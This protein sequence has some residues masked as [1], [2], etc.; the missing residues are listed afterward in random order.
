M[1]LDTTNW[2]K[3]PVSVDGVDFVSQ[4]DMDGS[5]Y[6]QLVNMPSEVFQAFHADMIHSLIGNPALISR[7]DLLEELEVINL[8][9]TQAILA[10][11]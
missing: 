11:A 5:F 7:E 10:L 2:A 1:S 6:P 9:A 8:G 4:I 3:F